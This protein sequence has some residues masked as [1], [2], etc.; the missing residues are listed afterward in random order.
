MDMIVLNDAIVTGEYLQ[1]RPK[2]FAE[3][4]LI[5][6]PPRGFICKEEFLT[7]APRPA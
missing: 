5:P 2:G 3:K 7:S 1:I 4:V 6:M